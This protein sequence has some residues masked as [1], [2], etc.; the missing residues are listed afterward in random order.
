[1]IAIRVMVDGEP[2]ILTVEDGA[3]EIRRERAPRH[4]RTTSTNVPIMLNGVSSSVSVAVE[5][6][7][8]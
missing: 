1:M 2:L 8:L 7:D 5:V 3:A 6:I 4:T